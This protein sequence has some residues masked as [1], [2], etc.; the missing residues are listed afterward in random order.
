MQISFRSRRSN[1]FGAPCHVASRAHCSLSICA[2]RFRLAWAITRL[3]R[4][5]G[6]EC[7]KLRIRL[8]NDLRRRAC[9]LSLK[10]ALVHRPRRRTLIEYVPGQILARLAH[11]LL[12]RHRLIA[13]Q[14]S[15]MS[16][17]C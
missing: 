11:R 8:A 4:M 7:P 6:G 16:V 12:L 15:R 14:S 10:F 13:A 9:R 5:L 2:F 1:I 3:R 17:S